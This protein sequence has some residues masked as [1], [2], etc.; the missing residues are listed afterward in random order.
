[1]NLG[2]VRAGLMGGGTPQARAIYAAMTGKASVLAGPGLVRT[3]QKRWEPW[4][5]WEPDSYL[6]E[7]IIVLE[8]LGV[9]Q[10]R[11]LVGTWWEPVGTL[12][13]HPSPTP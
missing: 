13:K 7:S 11:H 4:E 2:R 12:P 5:R 6:Y 1:M 8:R 9:R 10:G 3:L